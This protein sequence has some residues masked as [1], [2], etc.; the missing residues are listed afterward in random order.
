VQQQDTTSAYRASN[1]ASAQLVLWTCAWVATLAAARFGPE[2]LWD[3]RVLVSW[4]AVGLNVVAGVAWLVAFVRFLRAV[5]DLWRTIIQDALA[6]ALGVGL[7]AA[8]AYVVAEAAGLVA[9]E[10]TVASFA[11]L[12]GGVYLVAVAGGRLRYR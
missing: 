11:L 9:V 10:L 8:F 1:R 12:L 7:V 3:G 2:H 5:D 6:A 4:L